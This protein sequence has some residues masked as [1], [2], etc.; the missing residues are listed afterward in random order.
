[1]GGERWEI[2]GEMGLIVRIGGE[3]DVRGGVQ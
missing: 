3:R 2:I 1:M